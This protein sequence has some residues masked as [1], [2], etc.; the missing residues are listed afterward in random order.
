MRAFANEEL[1]DWLSRAQKEA[2]AQCKNVYSSK[3]A[4]LQLPEARVI[5]DRSSEWQKCRRG[6]QEGRRV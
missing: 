4:P 2:K 3:A 5:R 1:L 6:R